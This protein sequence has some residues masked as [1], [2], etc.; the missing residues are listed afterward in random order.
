MVRRH[1]GIP[2]LGFNGFLDLRFHLGHLR[3]PRFHRFL[4]A[5]VGPAQERADGAQGMGSF[6]DTVSMRRQRP[7]DGRQLVGHQPAR[8]QDQYQAKEDRSGVRE[9]PLD[10]PSH[11]NIDDGRKRE[12]DQA[13]HHDGNDKGLGQAQD[14]GDR[15]QPQ[16]GLPV[17]FGS[18]I[19]FLAQQVFGATVV[20]G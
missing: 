14:G 12:S 3:S 8:R 1:V 16:D 20:V 5:G 4:K 19:A 9:P 11:Q 17:Q 6:Q 13:G 10:P 2:G 18:Q 15:Q 7:G